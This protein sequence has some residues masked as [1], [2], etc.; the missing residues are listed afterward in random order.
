MF[1]LIFAFFPLIFAAACAQTPKA[2]TSLPV[3]DIVWRL[4][5]LGGQEISALTQAGRESAYL[6][7]IGAE[8]RVEGSGGC[9][10]FFG[11]YR[12]NG[13]R[14]EFAPL[15]S[16]RRACI[17][18]MENEDAFLKTLGNARSWQRQGDSL[19][20]YDAA[21]QLLLEMEAGK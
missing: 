11:E 10:R 12:Q 9:N 6:R 15:A 4:T 8:R 16:T 20:L 7:L 19:R 21:G 13:D 2:E 5:R 14:L 17:S 1:R 3:T 18:G